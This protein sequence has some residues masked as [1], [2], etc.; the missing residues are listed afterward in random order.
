MI[1]FSEQVDKSSAEGAFSL[2][3]EG[4]NPVPGSFSWNVEGTEMTYTPTSSLAI[5]TYTARLTTATKDPAGNSLGQEKSWNF[6]VGTTASPT[7][8]KVLTGKPAGGTLASLRSDDNDYFKVSGAGPS[9]YGSFAS[10]PQNLGALSVHRQGEELGHLH[11]HA[12]D[13][14]LPDRKVGDTR[15]ADSPFE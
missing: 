11:P 14:E 9:W 1:R 8:T 10:V 15:F 2:T 6:T 13:L 5:G 4:G 3:D 7:A 12:G